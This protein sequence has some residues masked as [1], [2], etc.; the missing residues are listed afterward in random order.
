MEKYCTESEL[1]DIK[2]WS[3]KNVDDLI[4]HLKDVWQYS[5]TAIKESFG[6]SKSGELVL[7]LELHTCGWS[8]NEDIISALSKN[9]LFWSMWWA[10]SERGGHYYFEI[11][12]TQVGWMKVSDFCKKNNTYRAYVY[13]FHNKYDWKIISHGL[14]LIR[15]KQKSN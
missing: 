5:G 12:Y 11:D 1:E 7:N 4:A 8:G 9:V 15:E 10:K 6:K 13:K 2:N 3:I 14:R